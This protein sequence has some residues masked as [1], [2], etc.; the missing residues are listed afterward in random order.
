MK[1]E[2]NAK[3]VYD[4][5][6]AARNRIS[7]FLAALHLGFPREMAPWQESLDFGGGKSSS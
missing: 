7:M 4:T 5:V 1:V 6:L 2:T 3:A